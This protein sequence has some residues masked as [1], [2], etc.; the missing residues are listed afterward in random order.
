MPMAARAV[1]IR[2]LLIFFNPEVSAAGKNPKLLSNDMPAN[3]SINHGNKEVIFTLLQTGS[4][5]SALSALMRILINEKTI[6]VGI[7]ESVRVSFTIVAKFPA[8]S[9]YANPAATTL[10]VSLT[11]VPA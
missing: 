11:A 6:T 1:T 10:D 5:L 7:M 2:N 3:A 8:A 4:L 9:L